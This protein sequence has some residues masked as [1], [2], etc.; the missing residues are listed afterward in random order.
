MNN[1]SIKHF[2]DWL[3]STRI[4]N[5]FATTS[6]VVPVT[7]AFHILAIC[8][9]FGAAVLFNLYV[10]RGL[11]RERPTGEVAARLLPW[12]WWAL[13]ILLG[14]GIILTITEPARELMS[15]TFR[16]KMLLILAAITVTAILQAVVS[17]DVRRSRASLARGL[18]LAAL[19][20][21]FAVVAAGRLIA[22]DTSAMSYY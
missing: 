6:W 1:Q 20:L 22:Y 2:C 3:S 17:R 8:A 9:L 12:I 5:E 15:N 4:S 19:V 7:Q 14:T 16:Y 10:L 18:A 11:D 13:P 21:W